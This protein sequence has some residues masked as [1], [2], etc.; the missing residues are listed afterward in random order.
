MAAR[1]WTVVSDKQKRAG[2]GADGRVRG[3]GRFHS[4]CHVVPTFVSELEMQ[5]TALTFIP[6]FTHILHQTSSVCS[7]HHLQIAHVSLGLF[8]SVH[9][10]AFAR[11]RGGIAW[12]HGFNGHPVVHAP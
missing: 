10:Q 4:F 1:W 3:D 12:R 6:N 11:H 9:F 5:L 7:K 8:N 2:S